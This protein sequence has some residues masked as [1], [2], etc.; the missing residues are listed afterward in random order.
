MSNR[1]QA[2]IV[3]IIMCGWIL[4][5]IYY[6]FIA[7]VGDLIVDVWNQSKVQISLDWE[8]GNKQ[9]D[10]CDGKCIFKWISPVNYTITAS[11]EG[12]KNETLQ[13]KLERNEI[14][15]L[16]FVL[17]KQ[18]ELSEIIKS[19]WDKIMELKYKKYLENA[20]Q[21][22]EGL[23]REVLWIFEGKLVSIDKS[24]WFH[25]FSF[26]GSEEKSLFFQDEAKVEKTSYNQYDWI[27]NYSIWGDNL[28]FDIWEKMS[29]KLNISSNVEFVK[30]SWTDDKYIIMANDWSYLYSAI[31]NDFTKNT[32]FDDFIVL[33]NGKILWLIKKDSK[34]K[35][36]LLNF[37]SNQKNKLILH[38]V[39]SRDRK[40]IYELDWIVSFLLS[41]DGNINYVDASWKMYNLKQLEIE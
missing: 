31:T 4:W 26:D 19:A 15:N 13:F 41:K 3:L 32:L 27:I 17:K 14:K 23:N 12:Y 29:Y 16:K 25:I 35:L 37:T 38:N 39:E 21:D 8:F 7:N 1:A 22:N 11:K 36:S 28:I 10:T 18:V 9:E 20:S 40:I 30:K 6:F 2:F 33:D 5:F 24:K 34:D